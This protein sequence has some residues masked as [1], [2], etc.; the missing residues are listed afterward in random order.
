[1]NS[2]IEEVQLDQLQS[3]YLLRDASTVRQFLRNNPELLPLLRNAKPYVIK[4]FGE[5]PLISLEVITDPEVENWESLFANIRTTLPLDGAFDQ[6]EKLTEEWQET[7][8]PEEQMV[9]ALLIFD[10]EFA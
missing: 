2:I 10:L 4:Y 1:L 3:T 6:L 5:H 7:L 8:T 9:S